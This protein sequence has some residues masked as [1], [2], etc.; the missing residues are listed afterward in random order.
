MVDEVGWGCLAIVAEEVILADFGVRE[1]IAELLEDLASDEFVIVV[2]DELDGELGAHD[3]VD[4]TQEVDKF[5][6]G[7]G[8][9]LDHIFGLAECLECLDEVVLLR[10]F[11]DDIDVSGALFSALLVGKR[12]RRP[13]EIDAAVRDRAVLD[14]VS[15]AGI[16]VFFCH[17]IVLLLLVVVDDLVEQGDLAQARVLVA[18]VLARDFQQ[19]KLELPLGLVLVE[20][21]LEQGLLLQAAA[22]L[23]RVHGLLAVPVRHQLAQLLLEVVKVD[24]KVGRQALNPLVQGEEVQDLEPE[25]V[26][27]LVFGLF[28]VIGPLLQVADVDDIVLR[29]VVVE[30]A[31]LQRRVVLGTPGQHALVA[32]EEVDDP[33]AE[34]DL[35]LALVHV[36]DLHVDREYAV[37]D[38]ALVDEVLDIVQGEV[39]LD[40]VHVV[41]AFLVEEQVVDQLVD[42]VVALD[43]LNFGQLLDDVLER[44]KHDIFELLLDLAEDAALRELH[45][46]RHR[47]DELLDVRFGDVLFLKGQNAVELVVLVVLVFLLFRIVV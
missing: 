29:E 12:L 33:V 30:V 5:F 2:I 3:L 8:V 35:E 25:I 10:G 32:E 15:Q 9:V 16:L 19:L 21:L 43:L 14:V 40:A 37:L 7:V 11:L 31:D 28:E 45:L 22:G 42:A 34:Q 24:E 39:L 26:V 6:L 38:H 23:K 13:L 44:G 18:V 27:V 46:L 36:I 1:D 17:G 4:G 41:D 20:I 47:V